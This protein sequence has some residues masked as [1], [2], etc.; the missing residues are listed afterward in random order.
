MQIKKLSMRI[1]IAAFVIIICLPWLPWFFLEKYIDVENNENRKLATRPTLTSDT[2]TT[3]ADDYETYFNDNIPFRNN[4]VS[5]H[6]CLDYY[7]LKSSP[8]KSVIIG[9]N[10]WLFYNKGQLEDYQRTNL[11]TEEELGAIKNAVLETQRYF[12]ERGIE[13]ILFIAPNKASI[14]GEYMPSY[15]KQ[16]EG[17]SRTEQ[18]V[19]Y[20][21]E[22]TTINIIF[23]EEDLK[24]AAMKYDDLKLF[25]QRDT[26]WNY[27]GGFFGTQPL[28]EALGKETI[29]FDDLTYVQVNEPDFIWN[30]YDLANMLGMSSILDEDT[31]YQLS[32]YTDNEVIYEGDVANDP[33]AFMS[34]IRTYSDAE[35]LRKVFFARDSFGQ[36]MTPYLACD[37]AEMYSVHLTY[38]TKAQIEEENPDIFIFEVVE[39]SGL[40]GINAN[41]W[42]EE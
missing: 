38:L 41:G 42:R 16:N 40:Y 28:L 37:F 29:S 7:V 15:I 13:F 11:Y 4:L 30:G 24:E 22:N 21:K 34:Y 35:D 8:S 33:D 12:D 3:F 5:L 23:P 14:Y 27:L 31:N 26:H 9:E 36:A 19:S 18:A 10:G 2:Y 6:N 1:Y 32:G 25:L 39:R 20:L 17:Y